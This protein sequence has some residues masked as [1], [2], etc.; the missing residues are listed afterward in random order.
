MPKGGH[1]MNTPPSLEQFQ[2]E[3]REVKKLIEALTELQKLELIEIRKNRVINSRRLSSIGKKVY[4]LLLLMIACG[5][6]LFLYSD[7]EDSTKNRIAESGFANLLPVVLAAVAGKEV[8]DNRRQHDKIK[9]EDD[10]EYE[11]TELL[12][13]YLKSAKNLRQPPSE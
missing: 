8:I 2:T 1:S 11:E 10:N 5:G 13:N 7:L 12:D 3:L 9:K 6:G 4:E